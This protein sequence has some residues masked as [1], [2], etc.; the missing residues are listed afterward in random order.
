M[1]VGTMRQ[2]LKILGQV[3]K[4]GTLKKPPCTWGRYRKDEPIR[5]T[6]RSIQKVWL[7]KCH[8]FCFD[9]FENYLHWGSIETAIQR[10]QVS[11][12]G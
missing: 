10:H 6:W 5:F 4:E 2:K 12:Q 9:L 1:M 8:A 7:I 3:Q 11:S